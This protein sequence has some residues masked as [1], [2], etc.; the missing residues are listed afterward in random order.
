MGVDMPNTPKD[1]VAGPFY[2][3]EQNG[4]LKILTGSVWKMNGLERRAACSP[5]SCY[6]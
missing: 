4:C 1:I 5:V 6:S 2:H 3:A